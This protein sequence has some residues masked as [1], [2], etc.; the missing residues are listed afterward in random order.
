MPK[1][2]ELKATIYDVAELAGVSLKTVSRVINKEPN[3]RGS[4]RDKVHKAIE[5]LQYQPSPSARGL[6]GSKSF[7]IALLY[8]NPSSSYVTRAQQGALEAC[9]AEGFGLLIQPCDYQSPDRV[10]ELLHRLKESR[11]DG[12]ILTP[13]LSD[14]PQ[15]QQRL[16]DENIACVCVAPRTGAQGGLSVCC[17]D[18][19][20]AQQI[21]EHLLAQ[22]HSRIGH[23]LG[24]PDHSVSQQRLRGYE[25]ALLAQGFEVDRSLIQQGRFDFVSGKQCAEELLDLSQPPTAIFASS[26]DMACGALVAAHER[27]LKLPGQLSVV[28]F[29]DSPQAAQCWPALSTV[30]QPIS[31]MVSSA[32]R[33]LIGELRKQPPDDI[34]STFQCQL[35]LRD[36]VSPPE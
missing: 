5:Q 19:R 23:I 15:L 30:R 2:S 28:G 3:V 35:H 16:A 12:A 4:T 9:G 26:D 27:G 24:H 11:V 14:N 29:D 7:L 10:G 32:A 34:Q 25:R 13:P 21:T 6:A 31:E 22:G 1:S 33:L 36:S 17:D 8:S 20:A 18:E